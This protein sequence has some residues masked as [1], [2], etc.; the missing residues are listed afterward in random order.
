MR[1]K[2][3]KFIIPPDDP[4]KNDLLNRKESAQIL[5][6][7]LKSTEEPL[8]LCVDAPWGEGKTTFLRMWEEHLRSERFPTVYFSAWENDF[9]EDALVSLLAELEHGLE[10]LLVGKSTARKVFNVMKELG[11]GLVKI[12]IP[13]AAKAFTAGLLDLNAVAK[14]AFAD[15]SERFAQEQIKKY[16]SSKHNVAD[17]RKKLEEFAAEIGK[18]EGGEEQ[19]VLPLVI[20]VDELDRCRPTYA[21]EVLEKVKHFFNVP[22][23]IFVLALHKEQFEHS[24][25][26]IYGHQLDV[27]GY[28]KRFIDLDYTLPKA[29]KAAF[30]TPQFERFGLK[31]FF[32]RGYAD[33]HHQLLTT[34]SELFSILGCSLR[35]QEHSFA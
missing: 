5:T 10:M 8:V 6:E 22:N 30:C 33:E 27:Q 26:R 16:E 4:F 28:L 23:V 2:A 7:L 13:A 34:L 11:A 31:E 35:E 29:D 12:G 21:I 15:L 18:T 20:L 9:S 1:L 24:I 14:S 25:D 3:P 17:F 32:E 19:R